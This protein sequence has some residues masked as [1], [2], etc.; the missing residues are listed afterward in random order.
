MRDLYLSAQRRDLTEEYAMLSNA[1]RGRQFQVNCLEALKQKTNRNF[2]MEVRIN[3]DDSK[4]HSFDIATRERDI[5]VECKSFSYTISGNI[6][7]AKITTLREAA[8]YLDLT[9]P[10]VHRLLESSEI[11][12]RNEGKPWDN[13]SCG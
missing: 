3:I 13:I 1:E 6:P 7:S 2:D 10:N 11:C 12:T 5:V 9:P 4:F 8:M